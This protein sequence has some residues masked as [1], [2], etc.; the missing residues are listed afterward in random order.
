MEEKETSQHASVSEASF[1]EAIE[2]LNKLQAQ[3]FLA[4]LLLCI[5]LAIPVWG[6]VLFEGIF[7]LAFIRFLFIVITLGVTIYLIS[8]AVQLERHLRFGL[9]CPYCRIDCVYSDKG[10]H[11]ISCG[12]NELERTLFRCS[13]KR[14]FA[15]LGRGRH[16]TPIDHRLIFCSHCGHQLG[17]KG[18]TRDGIGRYSKI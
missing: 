16:K 15:I 17:K 9:S 18:Y 5:S 4:A 1:D 7:H 8:V 13:C 12:S 3:S 2:R 10:Q 14:C 6:S 11:C